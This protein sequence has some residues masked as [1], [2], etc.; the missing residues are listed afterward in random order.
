ML[1]NRTVPAGVN[2]AKRIRLDLVLKCMR[3]VVAAMP[4]PPPAVEPEAL[5]AAPA[6]LLQIPLESKE[7]QRDRMD[8][9]R[10]GKPAAFTQPAG[11]TVAGQQQDDAAAA[12]APSKSETGNSAAAPAAADASAQQSKQQTV[13]GKD[14]SAAPQST[15]ADNNATAAAAAAGSSGAGTAAA[16]ADGAAAGQPVT[17]PT[18]AAAA[19]P[20]PGPSASSASGPSGGRMSAVIAALNERQHLFKLPDGLAGS[21]TNWRCFIGR[22]GR[23]RLERV[24][25]VTHESIGTLKQEHMAI[26]KHY[27][28]C[29]VGVV[30]QSCQLVWTM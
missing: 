6:N 1:G 22:G 7:K 18:A 24:D 25:H 9:F 28:V 19:L 14:D 15:A 13:G 16:T 26:Q 30:A 29:I 21:I 2:P 23:A 4:N 8:A 3:P 12:A 27:Q 17:P 10:R 20:P 11:P 5:W